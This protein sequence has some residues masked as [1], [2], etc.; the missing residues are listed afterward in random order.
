MT[1][2][3]KYTPAGDGII[4]IEDTKG[5]SHY[6]VRICF[7]IAFYELEEDA[8]RATELTKKR[9]NHYKG[10]WFHGMPCGRE[11]TWDYTDDDGVKWLGVTF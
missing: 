3:I 11:T 2:E 6:D 4:L 7:G 9:G 1:R 8:N 5:R 10:G